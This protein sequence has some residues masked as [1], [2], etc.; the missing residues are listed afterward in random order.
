[1]IFVFG[2]YSADQ[3]RFEL[4]YRGTRLRA[5]RQ[6]LELLFFL[7]SHNDR[8]VTREDLLRGPWRGVKVSDAAL[9]RCVMLARRALSNGDERGGSY[10]ETVRGRGFRF[11]QQV[12]RCDGTGTASAASPPLLFGRERELAM[13]ECALNEACADR[14]SVVLMTGDAGTG[15][16]ALCKELI[17]QAQLRRL[18][19][20]RGRSWPEL[21]DLRLHGPELMV[22][23]DVHPDHESSSVI[24]ELERRTV[25]APLLVLITSR[26]QTLRS[27]AKSERVRHLPLLGLSV[28]AVHSLIA[29]FTGAESAIEEAEGMVSATDG[30]PEFI[31]RLLETGAAVRVCSGQ[32]EAVC[33]HVPVQLAC[34]ARTEIAR[35]PEPTRSILGVA[36][37]VGREFAWSLVA[38][39]AGITLD[40][41]ISRLEPALLARIVEAAPCRSGLYRFHSGVVRSLL[42]ADL[43]PIR[44]AELH[45]DVGISLESVRSRDLAFVTELAR[46]F[47]LAT[48]HVSP[49]KAIRYNLEGARLAR[50]E[51][52]PELAIRKYRAALD[53][54][55]ACSDADVEGWL[56]MLRAAGAA[57]G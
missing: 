33:D 57:S 40:E 38:R 41:G 37:V 11:A 22:I 7:L 9:S 26:S 32:I 16:T 2:D 15:K 39:V 10:I 35:L 19:I 50:D 3:G 42:Y 14:G 56:E 8:V 20:R 6:V 46:H 13:L 27:Y 18:A 5:Q 30:N 44:R 48:P 49:T 31:I 52:A 28:G 23:E 47:S 21:A 4:R 53:L 45:R 43:P 12:R 25:A 36:A 29:S 55:T 54:L 24:T 34:A 17:A 51:R 1:M